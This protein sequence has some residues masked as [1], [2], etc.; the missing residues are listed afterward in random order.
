MPSVQNGDV[1]VAYEVHGSGDRNVIV[2]H[3]WGLSSASY[4]W[5]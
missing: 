2:V 4:G 1:T 5:S 3:G